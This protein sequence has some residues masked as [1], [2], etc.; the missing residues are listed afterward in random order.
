MKYDSFDNT[1]YNLRAVHTIQYIIK[2]ASKNLQTRTFASHYIAS[3]YQQ[4]K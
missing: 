2:E 4:I 1:P 3:V